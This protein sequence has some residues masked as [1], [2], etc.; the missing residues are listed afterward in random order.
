MW[1]Q[2]NNYIKDIKYI[3]VFA[4]WSLVLW[5]AFWRGKNMNSLGALHSKIGTHNGRKIG[6]HHR[7]FL[8]RFQRG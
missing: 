1:V 4:Y 7:V 2:L 5:K 3:F 8:A 6:T